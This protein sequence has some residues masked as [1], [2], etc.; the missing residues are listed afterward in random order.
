MTAITRH[1]KEP[2]ESQEIETKKRE[3]RTFGPTRRLRLRKEAE[4]LEAQARWLWFEWSP[5]EV[6][7]DELGGRLSFRFS[8]QTP[9]AYMQLGYR[10]GRLEG[11]STLDEI[12]SDGQVIF[13][14]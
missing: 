6:G 4:E 10:L 9:D 7:C 11:D 1:L 14:V 5:Y 3:R 12:L 8:T 2:L 13:P